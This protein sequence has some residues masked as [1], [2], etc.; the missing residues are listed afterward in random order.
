MDSNTNENINE[1]DQK[2]IEAIKQR[3]IDEHRKHSSLDWQLFAASKIH[4]GFKDKTAAQ[5]HQISGYEQTLENLAKIVSERGKEIDTLKKELVQAK[6]DMA[7]YVD[8][9][10]LLTGG[11]GK[12]NAEYKQGAIFYIDKALEIL[13]S[14]TKGK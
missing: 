2:D 11:L 13:K 14:I 4:A 8:V 5:D 10:D 3:I 7:K 12:I 6:V 1:L 9:A